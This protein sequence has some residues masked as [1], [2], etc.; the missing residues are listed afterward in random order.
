MTGSSADTITGGQVF[1]LGD[2]LVILTEGKVF[3]ASGSGKSTNGAPHI[4]SLAQD[5]NQPA[6]QTG[7]GLLQ[8]LAN[9]IAAAL[10]RKGNGKGQG[11]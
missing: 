1:K 9:L 8:P 2:D 6:H 3:T 5:T 11:T 7:W 10:G 4:V